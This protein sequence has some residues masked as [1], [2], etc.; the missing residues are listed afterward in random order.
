MFLSAFIF[1]LFSC[2]DENSCE[3]ECPAGFIQ[4]VNCDCFDLSGSSEDYERVTSNITTDAVWTADKVW[5]LGGRIAV[6]AGATLSIEPGTIIKGEAGAQNNATALLVARG[7]KLNACGSADAPIIFTSVADEITPER[8]A[9]GNFTSPNLDTNVNGLW[10]GLIILGYAPISVEGNGETAQIEGIPTSDQNGLYGGNEVSDNSGTICYVSIRHGG[11]NIGEGNEINGLT[12]GGVGR[13]TTINNIEVAANQDDG[14]EWFGGTV[15]VTNALVWGCGD[16]GMD[17]DQAW[18]GVCDN[19]IVAVPSG[20]SAME[21]DGPEGDF[22]QGCN[23]FDNGTIYCGNN[24]SAIVDWDDNTNTGVTNLY[25]YGIDEGYD[26]SV[27]FA[28]F[29]GDGECTTGT[30]E[31]SAPGGYDVGTLLQDAPAGAVTLVTEGSNSVG[32]DASVFG[33]TLGAQSG[34]LESIGLQ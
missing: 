9:A 2:G 28:S 16:D 29:G 15:T 33:W 13:S 20:G 18:N 31:Y 6:E 19:W 25:F 7:A 17:T 4:D 27:G 21:L 23:G 24:I 12:L 10:G 26:P 5:I 30:W 8:V 22:T 34:T 14:I 11:T 3:N 32:A 1:A